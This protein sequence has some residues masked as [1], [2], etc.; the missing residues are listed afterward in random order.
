M[1]LV[2]VENIWIAVSTYWSYPTNKVGEENSIFDH[3]SALNSE[4]TFARTLECFRHLTMDFH[5][6]IV[7][8]VSHPDLSSKA[9]E[10]VLSIAKPFTDNLSIYLISP[11]NLHLINRHLEEPMLRLDSYGNIRNVQL[12]V[13]YAMGADVVVGIDDD[14]IIEDSVY[15]EKVVRYIGKEYNGD[16][17]GGLAGP[18]YDRNGSF[19]LEGADQLSKS[20][21]IFRKK[22]YFMN[23]AL[24]KVMRE[25]PL[26]GI[27]RSNVAFG[28]NMCM[29]RKTIE[30]ICHDPFIPRGED[31]DYVIN[32]KMKGIN[33][34][35]Q[36][37]M[38]ITHLPPDS[39]ASQAGDNMKKLIADIQRFIYMREKMRFHR[40]RYPKERIDIDYLMPYPGVYLDNKVDLQREA[41]QCLD[42]LYPEYR[43]QNLPEDLVKNAVKLARNKTKE[44]FVYRDKWQNL[45][46]MFENNRSIQDTILQFKITV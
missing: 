16:F 5:I 41:I 28:G 43:R 27:V 34:Y 4:G 24:K 31:Y 38:K 42:E 18:Y 33:F 17:I 37:D 12:A 14:E 36:P 32:A 40:K 26:K 3:P 46:S 13:P 29:A 23:E 8:A 35:F 9:H 25:A 20:K 22:N 6:V 39:P 10:K 15:L 11:E 2:S 7:V 19:Q 30:Q 1:H 45:I 44:F 21:N